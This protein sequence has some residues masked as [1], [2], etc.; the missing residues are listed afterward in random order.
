[1]ASLLGFGLALQ[2]AASEARSDKGIAV[3]QE[4]ARQTRFSSKVVRWKRGDGFEVSAGGFEKLDE[5][6]I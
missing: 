2:L 1:M 3:M 4:E 5:S 6:G